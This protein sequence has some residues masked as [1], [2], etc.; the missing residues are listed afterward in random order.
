M[1]DGTSMIRVGTRVAHKGDVG[2][3]AMVS[4][5]SAR[6]EFGGMAYWLHIADLRALPSEAVAAARSAR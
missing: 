5:S 4:G 1:S 2:T 6:V 3:V